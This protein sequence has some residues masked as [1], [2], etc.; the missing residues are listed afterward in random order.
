MIT[1]SKDAENLPL[2]FYKRNVPDEIWTSWKVS[3][4]TM[5]QEEIKIAQ[6]NCSDSTCAMRSTDGPDDDSQQGP[7][8]T[9]SEFL[10]TAAQ[11]PDSQQRS[12][13][14]QCC[15][16]RAGELERECGKRA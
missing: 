6:K 4:V 1:V 9:D 12:R 15:R 3:D 11:S 14:I 5:F 8:H 7:E 16:S 10:Q 2:E 13:Q